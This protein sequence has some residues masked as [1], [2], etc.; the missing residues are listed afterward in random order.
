MQIKDKNGLNIYYETHGEG[1]AIFLLHH[2][3]G[4]TKMWQ[5][6]Y[7]KLIENGYQVVLIDRRGYG[8]SE[9]DT[10]FL[11]YYSSIQYRPD[12]VD[13]VEIIRQALGLEQINIVGQCEGGVV[14]IDYAVKYP[15]HTINLV[16]SSTL[17]HSD[18]PMEELNAKF[19]PKLFEDKHPHYQEKFIQ[20]HALDKA[21]KMYNQFRK[22]GGC[23]GTGYFDIRGELAKIKAPLLILYPDR[24]SLFEVEQAIGFYRNVEHGELA[25]LPDCGHNTYDQQPEAYTHHVLDFLIRHADQ[26]K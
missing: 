13:E 1:E 20:S 2:G 4:T 10:G 16:I 15:Q 8:Q 14:A 17:C 24:S 6:I 26:L 22:F 5:E 21:E 9:F 3:F 7:P 18:V 19:F 25:I 12:S 23:Y 11:D